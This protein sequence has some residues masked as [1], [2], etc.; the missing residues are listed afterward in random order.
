MKQTLK[1]FFIVGLSTLLTATTHAASSKSSSSSGPSGFLLELN[2]FP[3]LSDKNVATDRIAGTASTAEYKVSNKSG[4]DTRNS[5]SYVTGSGLLLGITYNMY[6]LTE[7]RSA[8][9]SDDKLKIT[10]EISAYGPSLGYALGNWRF[11]YTHYMSGE[12]K[13]HDYKAN[14]SGTV[15]FD[16]LT[17]QTG[18]EGYQLLIGYSF[19]VTG[20]F[21]LGTALV[22]Q[23]MVFKKQSRVDK[24]TTSDS[25]PTQTIPSKQRQKIS[26][27]DPMISF[28]F[29]F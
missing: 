9:A 13:F 10:D 5:I 20:W 4:F 11:I 21:E 14:S 17:K 25:F 8:S 6:T 26:S 7:S 18:M 24:V 3:T 16:N 12:R 29:R 15:T 23:N 1:F 28:M 19:P 2:F 22:N 27:W